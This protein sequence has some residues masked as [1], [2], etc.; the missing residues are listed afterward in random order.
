MRPPPE[1]TAGQ[2]GPPR[3]IGPITQ[4]DIVRFAGAGGDF[5][6]LHH[7]PE[8]AAAAG[9]STVISMGQ[10]QAGLLGSWL[11]DW[12]GIEHIRSLQVRFVAP[13]VLGDTVTIGGTVTGVDAGV[14]TLELQVTKDDG[15]VLTGTATTRSQ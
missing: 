6:P 8:F 14:A 11:S 2:D 15:P 4:T 3:T 12:V 10:F 13:L 9:F 7:D 5:N 1:L